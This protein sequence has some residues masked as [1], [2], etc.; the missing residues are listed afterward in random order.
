MNGQ[1]GQYKI[2]SNVVSIRMS[3]EE[4][5]VMQRIMDARNKKASSILRE[6]LALFKEQWERTRRLE[7]L[8]EH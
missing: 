7:T 1:S 5:D 6:A 2:K 3:D 8:R 4:R